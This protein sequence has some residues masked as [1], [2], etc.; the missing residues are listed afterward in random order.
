MS[1]S[2]LKV[3]EWLEGTSASVLVRESLWGFPLLVAIHILGLV[4]SVGIIVCLDFRLLGWSMRRSPVSVVYRQLMP[5]AFVGFGVMVVSGAFLFAAF[6][7]YAYGNVYFRLKT[8]A[9]LLAAV[10]A[11]YYHTTVERRIADWDVAPRPPL[12]A[13]AAGLISICSWTVVIV[14]GRFVS[15]T[16]YTR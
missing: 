5:W 9:M 3:C 2:A 12:R 4:L 14:A 13:R 11:L 8:A 6:A 10:N 15:Y 7:T 16:L 1:S